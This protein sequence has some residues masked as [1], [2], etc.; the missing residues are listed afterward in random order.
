MVRVWWRPSSCSPHMVEL[1]IFPLDFPLLAILTSST[2]NGNDVLLHPTLTQWQYPFPL[3]ATSL[4]IRVQP[5][6][7]NLWSWLVSSFSLSIFFSPISI[8]TLVFLFTLLHQNLPMT[9]QSG[10]DGPLLAHCTICLS[11]WRSIGWCVWKTYCLPRP[12]YLSRIVLDEPL[13]VVTFQLLYYARG[14]LDRK[15]LKT[16]SNHPLVTDLLSWAQHKEKASRN[17]LVTTLSF[18]SSCTSTQL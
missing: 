8:L 5:S 14:I 1:T 17:G 12:I 11:T 4:L 2:I 15:H 16:L 10:M 13:I 3:P 18:I 7:G 9:Q 6:P